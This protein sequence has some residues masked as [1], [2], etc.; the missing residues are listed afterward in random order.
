MIIQAPINTTGYGYTGYHISKELSL[1]TDVC[2]YPISSPDKDLSE[3]IKSLFWIN[4]KINSKDTEIKIWHQHELTTWITKGRR[5]GFPIFELT[6]FTQQEVASLNHCDHIFTTSK[7]AQ[8]IVHQHVSVP[9]S[10]IPLGVDNVIFNGLNNISRP[11]TIF[12]NCG[13]WEKRKGHDILI[14]CFNRAFTQKDNV[15]L[16]LMCDN[17]FLM[18]RGESWVNLCKSS[19][20]SNKIKIIPRQATQKNVYNIMRQIDCGVFPARAEGWNLELLEV[21]ACG[22]QVITTNYSAHTEFCDKNNA[23]LI[24]IDSLEL[25]QDGIWFHGQGLWAKIT[26]KQKEAVIH[27]MKEVHKIKQ[28][29]GFLN[30]DSGINT[31]QKFTWKNTAKSILDKI[32]D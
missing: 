20:L 22:K 24:E 7:W 6:H 12:F 11:E 17:P 30:N 1:L 3:D 8:D 16:W 19:H 32:G 13:K 14:E 9:T 2:L 28:S 5:V 21:L 4:K 18:D 29:A 25:A 31:S 26:E 15:E 27:H 10:V 23:R